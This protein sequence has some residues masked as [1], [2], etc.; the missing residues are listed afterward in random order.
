MKIK[1]N[2]P[3]ICIDNPVYPVDEILANK[4]KRILEKRNA[5]SKLKLEDRLL[6][7]CG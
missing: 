5:I 6:R 3:I 7:G 4:I 2:R 1:R